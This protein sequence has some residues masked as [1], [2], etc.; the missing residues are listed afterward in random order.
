MVLLDNDM[1]DDTLKIEIA[2][3]VAH[4]K[5]DLLVMAIVGSRK[6]RVG[7]PEFQDHEVKELIDFLEQQFLKK[8]LLD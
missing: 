2:E 3:D 7:R 5:D 4:A 8:N 1:S 6:F